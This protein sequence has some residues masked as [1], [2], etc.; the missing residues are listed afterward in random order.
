VSLGVS[1]NVLRVAKDNTY[2]TVH[3]TPAK[4]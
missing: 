3:V 2:A 1:F 4:P